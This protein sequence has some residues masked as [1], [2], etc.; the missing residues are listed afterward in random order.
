[1]LMTD[2]T[3]L[4]KAI[5]PSNETNK[6]GKPDISEDAKVI[7]LGLKILSKFF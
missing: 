2:K 5:L 6:K 7:A 1:M 4:G 3:S